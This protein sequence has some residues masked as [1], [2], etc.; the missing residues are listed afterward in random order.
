M[1][2]VCPS[3]ECGNRDDHDRPA[4]EMLAE[5]VAALRADQTVSRLDGV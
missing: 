1:S 5:V 4:Q 2:A 3:E